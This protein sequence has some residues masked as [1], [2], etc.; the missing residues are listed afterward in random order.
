MSKEEAIFRYKASMAVFKNWL[1]DGVITDADL[2]LID[3]M[4]AQKYGLSSCSIFLE[5][6]LLC[7]ENRGI[8]STA[9]GGRYG[10]KNHEN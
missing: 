10:Q 5:N 3:T 6:D 8:Y 2:L 9:K 1:D 4:L 7:K